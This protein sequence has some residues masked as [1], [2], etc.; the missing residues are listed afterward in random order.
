MNSDV[1]SGTTAVDQWT[2]DETT[3]AEAKLEAHWA[4][5]FL[6]TDVQKLASWGINA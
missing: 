1:F 4:S 2:F 3:G 6:E 5:Y